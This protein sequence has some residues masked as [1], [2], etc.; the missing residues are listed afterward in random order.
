MSQTE[1]GSAWEGEHHGREMVGGVFLE[2]CVVLHICNRANEEKISIIVVDLWG[3]PRT[4]SLP[5]GG[6]D[7]PQVAA[8]VF[9][10]V[11]EVVDDVLVPPTT[12]SPFR[13]VWL[14][15]SALNDV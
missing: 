2:G 13:P 1:E 10:Y 9:C 4:K 8:V 11:V 5:G 12:V 15:S 7:F 14:G 3:E 6:G